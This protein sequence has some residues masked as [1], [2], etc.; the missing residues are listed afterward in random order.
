MVDR[1]LQR[2]DLRVA[3][4]LEPGQIL[5][6]NNHWILHNRTAFEDHEDPKRRRHYVRLW[7]LR[8]DER[9]TG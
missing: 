1:L 7:L 2:D 4:S 3:F 6:T 8:S 9:P 5:F